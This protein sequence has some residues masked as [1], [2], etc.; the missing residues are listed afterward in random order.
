MNFWLTHKIRSF[1]FIALV[2]A[3]LGIAINTAFAHPGDTDTY[4]CHTC[5][6]NCAEW[7]DSY[8]YHCHMNDAHLACNYVWDEPIAQDFLVKKYEKCVRDY[9]ANKYNTWTAPDPQYTPVPTPQPTPQCPTFSHYEKSNDTCVC[10]AGYIVS[11]DKC[12]Y[13]NTYCA[14]NHGRNSLFNLQTS[15]CECANGYMFSKIFQC[16]S[17]D[18]FCRYTYGENIKYIQ[19]I[20]NCECN[21]GYVFDKSSNSCI[22][23]D[24]SCKDI[25][26]LNSTFNSTSG[27]CEC[28]NEYEFNTALTQCI[29][30]SVNVPPIT[31]QTPETTAN[32]RKEPNKDTLKV[33]LGSNLIETIPSASSITTTSVEEADNNEKADAGWFSRLIKW[34]FS[35]FW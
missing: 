21:S 13:A 7:G 18:D 2:A 28:A 20:N 9:E 30:K 16:V 35:I 4:G 29:K 27:L 19:S 24:V 6:T 3:L 1:L 32:I 31:T 17:M 14:D 8:G 23:G 15:R 5:S 10:N 25:Y 33:N 34:V 26:G 22:S 12:V 11:G